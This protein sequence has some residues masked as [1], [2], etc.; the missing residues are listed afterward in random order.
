MKQRVSTPSCNRRLQSSVLLPTILRF[1]PIPSSP[2]STA[3]HAELPAANPAPST[4]TNGSTAFSGFGQN[5]SDR[6]R[7][8]LPPLQLTTSSGSTTEIVNNNFRFVIEHHEPEVSCRPIAPKQTAVCYVRNYVMDNSTGAVPVVPPLRMRM[9]TSSS[10]ADRK[11]E[12]GSA[13]SSSSVSSTS[14]CA[15]GDDDVTT[16]ISNHFRS[17]TSST[18]TTSSAADPTRKLQLRGP[19]RRRLVNGGRTAAAKSSAS[20]TPFR[21]TRRLA[22]NERERLRMHSLNDAFD[23]LRDVIPCA[24]QIGGEN[25]EDGEFVANPNNVRRGRRLSKIETL[26]LAKNYIKSLTNVI[27]EMRSEPA[28]YVIS[29]RDCAVMGRRRRGGKRSWEEGGR[30]GTAGEGDVDGLN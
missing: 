28:P 2:T 8:V 18:C 29:E 3:N 21:A 10:I 7:G 16:S 19:Q 1:A 13:S 30:Q 24:Q 5:G 17:E 15:S 9:V 25:D 12:T 22:S 23:G 4:S 6:Q 14:G 20:S 27:C 26:T 11:Q